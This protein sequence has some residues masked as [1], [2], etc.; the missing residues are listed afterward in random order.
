MRDSGKYK[1]LWK[2]EEGWGGKDGEGKARVWSLWTEEKVRTVG[3]F[4]F[5]FFWGGGFK[6]KKVEGKGWGR[7][8]VLRWNGMYMECW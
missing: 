7:G 3:I 8:R 2:E 4:V 1:N 5:C 6:I